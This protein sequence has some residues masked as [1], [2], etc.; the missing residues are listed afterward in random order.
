[1]KR[2]VSGLNLA[3][4]LVWGL[5]S[6]IAHGIFSVLVLA[7]YRVCLG[8]AMAVG[9]IVFA[10]FKIDSSDSRNIPEQED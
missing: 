1:M 3:A 10:L 5:I 2:L 7:V 8:A 4:T 9:A 6:G